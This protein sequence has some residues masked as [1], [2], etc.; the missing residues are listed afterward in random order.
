M[1][2]D[3]KATRG[4]ISGIPVEEDL[5][6]LKWC[7]QG[8]KVSRV[9]RLLQT[10]NGERVS[11]LSVLLEFEGTV[12]PDRVK[13][14]CM[15]FPVRV[16]V[17]PPLRCYKWQRY[18]HIAVV[19]KGKQK[20]PKCGGEHRFE[21]CGDNVLDKC[22]NCGGQHRVS[23]GGCEVSKK[24]VEVEQ[25]KVTHN[26]SYAEAVRRVQRGGDGPGKDQTGLPRKLLV[27]IGLTQ[28]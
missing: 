27:C 1:L 11:S 5:E 17:P 26:I 8:G 21:E 13:I 2:G 24:A 25:V 14:G 3:S 19:C 28:V 18:G 10:V 16:F 9:K 4:V 20:C 23:F 6:K 22:S 15:S 7:I 12:L